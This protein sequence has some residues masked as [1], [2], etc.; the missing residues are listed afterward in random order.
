M[1]IIKLNLASLISLLFL[2]ILWFIYCFKFWLSYTS[3][4]YFFKS[5]VVLNIEN[6]NVRKCKHE[7]INF[8]M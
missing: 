3:N 5:S 1:I 2:S 7:S 4:Q 6:H 8:S